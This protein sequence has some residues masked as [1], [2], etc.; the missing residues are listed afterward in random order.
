MAD[1]APAGSAESV[2]S[3][4]DRRIY[5][6]ETALV[7]GVT[8]VMTALVFLAVVWR[9]FAAPEGKLAEWLV[10]F[11]GVEAAAA[12]TAGDVLGVGL[13]LAITVLAVRTA[14][15][16]W[17]WGRVLG[18][19]VLGGAAAIVASLVFVWA[20]PNGLVF[21]QKSALALLM[22]VVLLGS[23]MAA[24]TRRHIFLQ[25]A[26]K[27]VPAEQQRYHAAASLVLAALFTLFLAW[28]GA[29]YAWSNWE[30]WISTNM[31]SGTF[32]SVAIPHWTVTIAIP[33]GFGLTAARFVG[34]AVAI[35][36]GVIP[37]VPPAEEV[38]AAA[39]QS[40]SLGE[41]TT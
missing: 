30:S 29:R 25:A 24:H 15:P 16:Q 39:A 41:T 36:R 22:W 34:Q 6:V 12:K 26:Q 4:L 10:R 23:S 11:G 19:G 28:V 7:I 2:W 37:P 31:H 32:E 40:E 1:P 35:W 21:A 14:R 17:S 9:V 8:A 33:I 5:R 13:W 27:L 38:E 20:M 3:R 18:V